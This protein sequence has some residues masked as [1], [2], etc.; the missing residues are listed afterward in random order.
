MTP[1]AL[2]AVTGDQ[3]GV[4]DT[5]Q[6]LRYAQERDLDLGLPAR[7]PDDP[8][9]VDRAALLDPERIERHT[10]EIDFLY[11]EIWSPF[12]RRAKVLDHFGY[13]DFAGEIVT[14]S[15]K[16][17]ADVRVDRPLLV[18]E[19]LRRGKL[20]EPSALVA[21]GKDWGLESGE[22][23]AVG[24]A[25]AMVPHQAAEQA[26]PS[27]PRGAAAIGRSSCSAG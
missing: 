25:P 24:H 1:G 20:A 15:G 23:A 14:E 6:A 10:R 9:V 19:A 17:L 4:V 27:A 26:A 13:L 7:W 5:Q 2:P 12:E 8:H 22:Q 18:G 21:T 3:I 16:W 11:T